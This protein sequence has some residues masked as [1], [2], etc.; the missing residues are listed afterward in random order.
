M[1][2]IPRLHGTPVVLV[3]RHAQSPPL[4]CFSLEVQDHPSLR[5]NLVCVDPADGL[6]AAIAAAGE[7]RKGLAWHLARLW[8]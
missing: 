6:A 7:E 3:E 1:R 2:K 4:F 8:K 5:Y